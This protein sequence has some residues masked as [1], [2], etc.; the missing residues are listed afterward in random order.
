MT[1]RAPKQRVFTSEEIGQLIRLRRKELG[2]TQEQV[3]LM[4][5]CS[6]RLIGEIER[7]RTTVGIQRVIDLAT[8][9]GIDITLSIRGAS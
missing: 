2:Y 3:A 6:A 1:E 7:G 8:N 5:N 9:L 4:S